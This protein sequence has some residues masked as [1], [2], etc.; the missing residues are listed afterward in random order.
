MYFFDNLMI[1]IK[2]ESALESELWENVVV[3]EFYGKDKTIKQ[4]IRS[5]LVI[6]NAKRLLKTH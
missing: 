4:N 1:K 3:K 6:I 5:N 2:I